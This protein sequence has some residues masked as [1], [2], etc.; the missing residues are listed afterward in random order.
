MAGVSTHQSSDRR[1]IVIFCC[2]SV[3]KCQECFLLDDFDI[4]RDR[5]LFVYKCP[6]CGKEKYLLVEYNIL[7][8]DFIFNRDKPKKTKEL[9]QWLKKIKEKVVNNKIVIKKGN[10]SNMGF[11]FGV[12]TPDKQMGKDFNGTVRFIKVKG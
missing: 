5:Q 10:K 8:E 6:V 4:Y 1:T 7:N 3:V 9:E 12:N 11:I 2:N